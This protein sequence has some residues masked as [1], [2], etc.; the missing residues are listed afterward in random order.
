MIPS[1]YAIYNLLGTNGNF[2]LL[3]AAITNASLDA[4]LQGQGHSHS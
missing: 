1:N 4:A 2:S 3:Y